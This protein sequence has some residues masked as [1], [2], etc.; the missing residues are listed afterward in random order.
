[1]QEVR[2]SAFVSFMKD[3]LSSVSILG[4]CEEAGESEVAYVE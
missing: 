4:F 2:C 3:L 1:M